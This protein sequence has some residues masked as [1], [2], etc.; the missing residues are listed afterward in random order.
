M[1][2]LIVFA[3]APVKGMVKKRL[4]ESSPL[5]ED[6][7]C[8][9]YGAFLKD[10]LTAAGKT[11]ADRVILNYTPFEQKA[12]MLSFANEHLAGKKV[13]AVPQHPGDFVERINASFHYDLGNGATAS[14]MIGSDSPALTARHIDS[15]FSALSANGGVVLGPSGE[16]GIYLIGLKSGLKFNYTKIFSQGAELSNFAREAKEA[17]ESLKILEEVT[18]VDVG[19]DLVTIVS[20]L[21][22][23]E[24]AGKADSFPQHTFDTIK[25]LKLKVERTKGTRSKVV[26]VHPR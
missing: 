19:C 7:I 23:M 8:L 4:L 11:A 16:G 15:A 14:V 24:H 12:E 9:L 10:T 22:A 25:K 2:S 20:L 18:D 3:K 6:D 21:E 26:V 13:V 5:N 1:N 17:G